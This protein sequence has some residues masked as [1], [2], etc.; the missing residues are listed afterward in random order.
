MAASSCAFEVRRTPLVSYDPITAEQAEGSA[1]LSGARIH[2]VVED[3]RGFES[4][5]EAKPN[6][7]PKGYEATNPSDEAEASWK[8]DHALRCKE[9]RGPM[10]VIG[11]VRNGY[12]ANTAEV[13][14][15]D[16]PR[17]WILSTVQG[18]LDRQGAE[19]AEDGT[20]VRIRLRYLHAE[21]LINIEATMVIDVAVGGQEPVVYVSRSK[22]ATWAASSWDFY[23]TLLDVQRQ[24]VLHALNHL[25]SELDPEVNSDDERKRPE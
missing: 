23:V 13:V 21:S 7:D 2:L 3:V 18:E 10:F 6:Q 5:A 4:W 25:T 16:A 24:S 15:P 20:A 22:R 11:S 1:P 19:V 17:D 9:G 12:G 8:S 14:S